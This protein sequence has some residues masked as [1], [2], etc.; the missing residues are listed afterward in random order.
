VTAGRLGVALTLVVAAAVVGAAGSR[1]ASADAGPFPTTQSLV[2]VAQG[3]TT[4]TL[5]EAVQTAGQVVFTPVGSTKNQ[6]YNAIGFRVADHYIYGI[7]HNGSNPIQQNTLVRVDQAGGVTAKCVVSGLPKDDYNQGTFADDGK[8][9]VRSASAST[10]MFAV[11]VDACT[12]TR[13]TLSQSVPNVSDIIF[14]Q[15]FFW[16]VYGEGRTIYR[17]STTG[18]VT[19][20]SSAGLGLGTDPFGAQWVYGNGNIGVSNN[21]SGVVSQ[22]LITNATTTPT[23]TVVSR[24]K[25]PANSNNDGTSF[26]ALPADLQVTKTAVAAGGATTFVPGDPI[27]YTVTITNNG[28]G[29]SSGAFVSDPLPDGLT[30]ATVSPTSICSIDGGL[31]TCAVGPMAVGAVLTVMIAAT[32]TVASCITNTVTVVGNEDTNPANNAAAAQICP[33]GP[34]PRFTVS[35]TV[36]RAT[37]V[38]GQTVTYTIVAHNPGAA[39]FTT[40]N[41]AS[42]SDDLSGVLD[43]ATYND[44]AT[45]SDGSDVALADGVLS[46]SGALAGGATVTVTFSVTVNPAGT[47]D[48]DLPNVVVPGGGGSCDP[49]ATCTT[50]TRVA[51]FT[52]SKSAST[53]VLVPGATITY[54]IAVRNT[55]RVDYTITNPASF[56][57]DLTDV[58]DDATYNNDATGGATFATPVVSWIGALAQGQTITVQYTVTVHNPDTGDHKLINAVVTPPGGGGD[59]PD[60]SPD[61]KCSVNIPTQEFTVAKTVDHTSALAGDVVTYAVT[62]TNTGTVAYTTT[63]PA[64]FTDDLSGVLDDATFNTATPPAFLTGA[65]LQWSGPLPVGGPP[66]VITYSVTVTGAGDHHLVNL[67]VPDVGGGG[68]CVTADDCTTDTP[69]KAFTVSKTVDHTVARPGDVVTYAVTVTNTGA[70]EYTDADPASFADDL[71][72][73]LDQATINPADLAPPATLNGTTL[74]WSGPLAIGDSATITYSVTVNDPIL[75]DA[76]LTNNVTPDSP[77]GTCDPNAQCSTDVPLQWFTVQKTASPTTTIEGHTVTYTIIVAAH[78]TAD[79]TPTNPASL[80]DNLTDVLD[81]ATYNND[82][83][84]GATVTGSTLAWTGALAVG[85]PHTITYSVTV[86]EPDTADHHLI[87]VLVPGVNGGGQCVNA[88]LCS[89]DTPVMSFTTTKTVN[90]TT[91]KPGTK[92]TYTITV[93]NTGGADYTTTTPAAL[94][95]DL[96]R[97][98]DDANYDNDATAGAHVTGHTLTWTGAL[99]VGASTTITYS[100]T[101]KNPDPGDHAL[102][103]TVVPDATTGGTCPTT[104]DCQT[105]VPIT[106]PPVTPTTVTPSGECDPTPACPAP[107]NTPS[108]DLGASAGSTDNGLLPRTGADSMPVV[109]L[110]LTL[111]ST[112]ASLAQR[113][114]RRNA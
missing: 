9:Y 42:F 41:P 83:T 68:G 100:V 98:L 1:S 101:V 78:G 99:A 25:G 86:H 18:A 33:T 67:V 35:K 91:A 85:T 73:V 40:D 74:R 39:D 49:A 26:V 53:T 109:F 59:C 92:I 51:A 12:A 79:Y 102:D 97:V 27:T 72:G 13:V 105:H 5:Y 108:N 45:A 55:G 28:P 87:N 96:T 29:P 14:T 77:G 36:D 57:D 47:G 113:R 60:G 71:T 75:G 64:S 31:L 52:I 2:F 17:I 90:P 15:G 58:L 70:V 95:D 6:E 48:G 11:D 23:F 62:V 69:I 43:D 34:P 112:G 16:A 84:G 44:D 89:T 38:P 30:A 80:T 7:A 65:T 111:I 107:T 106:T 3:N 37:A 46:W 4:T 63:D 103:N 22:V 88:T 110:A 66:V 21:V 114:R 54:T 82:A 94:T 81:D 56:T 10:V 76:H 61:P 93:T 19:A 20:F 50:D 32:T 24:I 8:L 104:T